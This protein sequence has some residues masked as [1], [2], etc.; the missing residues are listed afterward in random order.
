M[1][2]G[3]MGSNAYRFPRLAVVG[4]ESVVYLSIGGPPPLVVRISIW[5]G[6]CRLC[7]NGYMVLGWLLLLIVAM[8]I[9]GSVVAV[10]AG[11]MDAALPHVVWICFVRVET[12]VLVDDPIVMKVRVGTTAKRKQTMFR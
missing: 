6:A 2:Y 1:S 7:S 11:R 4:V 12:R 9:V 8:N 10:S 3:G 5:A